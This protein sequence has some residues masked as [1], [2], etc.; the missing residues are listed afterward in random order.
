MTSAADE[1]VKLF[2]VTEEESKVFS[3]IVN[4][5]RVIRKNQGQIAIYGKDIKQSWTDR[6]I[7]PENLT[8]AELVKLPAVPIVLL[9]T[10]RLIALSS[11]KEEA[12][13]GLVTIAGKKSA[14][15]DDFALFEM[16]KANIESFCV[17]YELSVSACKELISGKNAAEYFVR[18][19]VDRILDA[20]DLKNTPRKTRTPR[21]TE[22]VIQGK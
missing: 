13:Y 19:T 7:I 12:F 5:S 15:V 3:H 10:I 11:V 4:C 16:T 9:N 21:T 17:M 22:E 2:D 18:T 14:V 8:S 1:S 20:W 6:K